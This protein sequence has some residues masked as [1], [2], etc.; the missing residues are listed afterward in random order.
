MA[1]TTQNLYWVFTKYGRNRL[2]N[3]VP[4]DK[5]YL[6]KA[7]VGSYNW[8]EDSAGFLTGGYSEAGFKRY[9]EEDPSADLGSIQGE[10]DITSKSLV[11]DT[12][13]E[14]SALVPETF[15]GCTIC[16]FGI[17]ETVDG[18][19]HLF[20][21]C[22]MQGIYKPSIETNHYMSNRFNAIL[23][24]R[25]LVGIYD[26]IVLN[27]DSNYATLDQIVEF[28][29][30]LLFV[31]SNLAEQISNNTHIIG[32][33]RAQQ[34]YEKM[35]DDKVKFANFAASTTYANFL[36]ATS[37]DNIP[38]FWVFKHNKTL[39]KSSA[40]SDLG[41]RGINLGA[42]QLSVQYEQGY[43]GICSWLNFNGKNN[44]RLES[45]VI[46]N[47]INTDKVAKENAYEYHANGT[48]G[49]RKPADVT[50]V[51]EYDNKP[52]SLFWIG[53]HNDKTAHT[54]LS[55]DNSVSTDDD[56]PPEF[57][58]KVTEKQ[59]LEVKLFTNKEN[60]IKV[61]SNEGSIPVGEFY[62]LSFS[63]TGD[64]RDKKPFTAFV[65]SEEI[66]LTVEFSKGIDQFK[67]MPIKKFKELQT[68]L[69]SY[70]ITDKGPVDYVNSKTAMIILCKDKLSNDYVKATIFNLMAL[71]GKNPCLV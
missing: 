30:N 58:F 66:G 17:Y 4:G 33:N 25:A 11:A 14:L 12:R 27:P 37:L 15:G 38:A 8:Y 9:F 65:N 50:K 60:Y 43:E 42:D 48:K 59:Q 54:L 67:G 70:T 63:Y 21:V 53:S 32:L 22:T 18:T 61:V 36:N 62:V 64:F 28:Q 45:D 47:L 34:L 55:K 57:S 6:Y 71:I 51:T 26:A 29:D 52:F 13:V 44:Y 56:N 5:L 68:P 19:D 69:L 39:S 35:M 16:E 23:T 7:K 3:F 1:N 40:I 41:V 31:E 20:A 10:F 2:I 24:S 49:D 46:F